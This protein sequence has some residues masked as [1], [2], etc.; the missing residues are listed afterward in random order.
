VR[1]DNWFEI[2]YVASYDGATAT[3]DGT[4]RRKVASRGRVRQQ[5]GAGQGR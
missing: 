2:E 1:P 5:L 3:Q 4:Y